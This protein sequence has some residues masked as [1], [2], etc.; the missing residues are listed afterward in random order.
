MTN[1]QNVIE[2]IKDQMSI[3]NISVDEANIQIIEEL[4]FR[5]ITNSLTRQVRKALNQ[6]V[7][8]GRLVR[9][10]KDGANAE[11]FCKKGFE[12]LAIIERKRL[13]KLR[14]DALLKIYSYK[15]IE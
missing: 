8:D 5:V 10:K 6:G 12:Y 15:E 4:R 1:E 11:I 7:K 2:R 3:G 13:E 14:L 9:I